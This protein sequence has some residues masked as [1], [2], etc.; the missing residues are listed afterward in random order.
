MNLGSKLIPVNVIIIKFRSYLFCF[1]LKIQ[2]LKYGE[3][4]NIVY[5]FIYHY[6]LIFYLIMRYLSDVINGNNPCR[7]VQVK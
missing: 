4:S 2:N 6:L 7:Q 3:L 5:V 1:P